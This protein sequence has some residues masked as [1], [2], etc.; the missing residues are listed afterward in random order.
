MV[1]LKVAYFT[2]RSTTFSREVSLA[3]CAEKQMKR[4]ISLSLVLDENAF[5]TAKNL[6][7]WI[8]WYQNQL[9]TFHFLLS[10]RVSQRKSLWY[11][12]FFLFLFPFLQLLI[13]MKQ[14][15]G[16]Y[17]QVHL[18]YRELETAWLWTSH[19]KSQASTSACCTIIRS[20]TQLGGTT[21]RLKTQSVSLWTIFLFFSYS[22]L[23]FKLRKI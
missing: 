9:N 2:E 12:C 13:Q 15:Y 6:W 3:Q 10:Y 22:M 1:F 14:Q 17:Q 5:R 18:F 23:C 4:K 19:G 20:F 8:W 11:I 7:T 16:I 21:S